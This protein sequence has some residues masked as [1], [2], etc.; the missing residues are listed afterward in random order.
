MFS[1]DIG[2]RLEYWLELRKSLESCLDP[3][4]TVWDFWHSAPFS[5]YN[6]KVDPFYQKNWPTPWEIITDN[7]YD[8]F[9]KAL[10][11]GWTLKMTKRYRNSNIEIKTLVDINDREYNIVCVDNRWALNFNDNGPINLNELPESFRLENLIE[12]DAPR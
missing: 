4:E 3:L 2:Q 11:I 10:M 6:N 9:T 1:K 12:L 5:P 8:D 7:I